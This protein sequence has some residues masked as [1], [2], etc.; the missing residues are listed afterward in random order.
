MAYIAVAHYKIRLIKKWPSRTELLA[1]P[2]IRVCE[3]ATIQTFA[4]PE[5]VPDRPHHPDSGYKFP[6]CSFG[7]KTVVNKEKKALSSTKADQAFVS[8]STSTG[9]NIAP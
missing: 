4:L 2:G 7:K 1:I 8:E 3:M 6:E 5:Y 9:Y